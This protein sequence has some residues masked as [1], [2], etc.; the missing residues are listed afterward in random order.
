MPLK[1]CDSV[2]SYHGVCGNYNDY[3]I[4]LHVYA[5][6]QSILTVQRV[7]IYIYLQNIQI[8]IHIHMHTHIICMYVSNLCMNE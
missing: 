4:K 2:M 3:Q 1:L 5:T 7:S 6:M 8:Q